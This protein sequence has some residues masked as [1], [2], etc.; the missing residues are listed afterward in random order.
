ME[1]NK[2]TLVYDLPTRFFHGLFAILFLVSFIIAETIDEESTLFAYHMLAG[3]TIVFLLV[4][5]FVWGFIGTAYARFSSFELNPIKLIQYIKD[6]VTTK[7]KQY[8]GHNPASS[9]AAIVMFICAIGLA[10]TGI[11]MVNGNGNDFY[12]ESHEILSNLFMITVVLHVGGIIFHQFKHNDSLWSSMFDGKKKAS[13]EGIGISSSKKITGLVFL[14]LTLTWT[15]YLYT[16]YNR[17]TQTL[18]LFGQELAL[19]E[20]EHESGSD[21]ETENHEEHDD[22]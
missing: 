3:L 15:G 5:R 22:D 20:A 21:F 8:M 6:T 1:K 7:T 14:V 17:T 9:Y 11:A 19:G 10:I 2:K 12:E 4:L 18:N 16:N 13:Q